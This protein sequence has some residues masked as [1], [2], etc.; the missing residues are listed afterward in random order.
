[1]SSIS[2]IV[3]GFVVVGGAV[4]LYRLARRKGEELKSALEEFQQGEPGPHR[5]IELEQD[6]ASGVYRRKS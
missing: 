5:V 1:M 2:G 4:A 3:A 6:P